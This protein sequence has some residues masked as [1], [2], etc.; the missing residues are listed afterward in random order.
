MSSQFIIFYR[1]WRHT[2]KHAPPPPPPPKNRY[3]NFCTIKTGRI[4][5]KV[6]FSGTIGRK[7]KIHV[8]A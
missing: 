1:I 8:S 3:L 5:F 2:K 4:K 6:C 7:T